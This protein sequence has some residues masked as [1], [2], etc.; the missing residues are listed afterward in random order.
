MAFFAHGDGCKV[1]MVS[2]ICFEMMGFIRR[3]VFAV[4]VEAND[5]G[6]RMDMGEVFTPIHLTSVLTATAT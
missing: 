1:R 2:P 4:A 6:E 5:A 3:S